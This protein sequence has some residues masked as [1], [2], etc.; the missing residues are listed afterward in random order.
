MNQS[1]KLLK[2]NTGDDIVCKTE[3]NLSLKDK[4]SIF[5]QDPMVLNQIRVPY[6][7]GVME[8]YTLSPWM[9]MTEDDFYEIPVRYI[10]VA[11]DIKENLKDNYIKYVQN[12]KEAEL[13]AD[14]SPDDDES[15]N[16]EIEKE[17]NYE[18]S[19]STIKRRGRLVH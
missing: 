11:A 6:G 4:E 1:Y 10:I 17:T 19:Q 8:S 15:D 9:A 5:V 2:L 18:N 13:I 14:A 16:S 7:S 12:R 3:E